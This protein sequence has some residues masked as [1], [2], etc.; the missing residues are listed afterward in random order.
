M[1]PRGRSRSARAT[2]V[3]CRLCQRHGHPLDDQGHCPM[4]R[5]AYILAHWIRQRA[6]DMSAGLRQF[7]QRVL[8]MVATCFELKVQNQH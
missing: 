6:P 5:S 7:V 4:C 3:Q 8:L 2:N 1:P